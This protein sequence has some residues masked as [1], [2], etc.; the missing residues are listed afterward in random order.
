MSDRNLADM[1]DEELL[2]MASPPPMPAGETAPVTAAAEEDTTPAAADADPAPAEPV[3]SEDPAVEEDEGEVASPGSNAL[4]DDEFLKAGVQAP[5]AAA[6]ATQA[7][8]TPTVVQNQEGETPAAPAVDF[9][10][11]YKEVMKPFKAN[12]KEIAP[13][14]MDE[15]I[16]LMQMG[17]NYTKKL[18]T[19]QPYRRMVMMLENHGIKSEDQLSFLIDVSKKNPEAVAKLLKDG[20]IDPLDL[21]TS[22]AN[23]Y[24]P[25]NY[26]V[27]DQELAFTTIVDEVTSTEEG[28]K[29]AIQINQTWD[30][31]SKERLYKEPE[32]LPV[33][34]KQMQDGTYD[35]IVQEMDRQKIMG[36]IPTHLPFIEAYYQTGV[37]MKAK[38][39]TPGSSANPAPAPA[40]QAVPETKPAQVIETRPAVPPK[41]QPDTRVNGV[42]PVRQSPPARPTTPVNYFT[43]S[44]E[45]FEKLDPL[46]DRRY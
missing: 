13:E 5:V 24:R 26:R 32:I 33:I 31:A 30:N 2:S 28:S 9:E 21:D 20:G 39:A 10:T 45:E 46:K 19:L 6:P 7:E 38:S 35:R 34:V 4:A 11:F 42:A 44:D 22:I 1:S 17:A 15:V 36:M 27:S 29:A 3:V 16:R 25:G 8:D 23:N 37:A 41:P 18:Q 14:N 43:L 12:G 40:G